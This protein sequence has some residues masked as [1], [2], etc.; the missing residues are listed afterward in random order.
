MAQTMCY[1]TATRLKH[2][3]AFASWRSLAVKGPSASAGLT[4]RLSA[5]SARRWDNRG[6]LCTIYMCAVPFA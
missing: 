3:P 4:L 5:V 1:M 2:I 6:S